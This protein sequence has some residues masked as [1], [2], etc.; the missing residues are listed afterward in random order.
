[1]D[2]NTENA[3]TSEGEQSKGREKRL[4]KAVERRTVDADA[5]DSAHEDAR[6]VL[7][8]TLRLFSDLSNE[9]FR[10][11]R[12]NALVITILVAVTSQVT[13]RL[14]SN[15][16][17]VAS[18]LL[19][20]ASTAFALAGYMT[21]TVNRGIDT[22]TFGKLTTYKLDQTEYLNWV[23]T[24]GYP[25]WIADGVRKTDRKEQWIRRSFVAFF[26][27]FATLLAGILLSLY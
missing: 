26:A 19:F 23:L 11:I 16:S 22:R 2:E 7:E 25:K 17:S 24:L 12:L 21:T 8:Q 20:V 9:A 15:V 27:G 4:Q 14:Y 5:L 10:L 3:E 1:M 18:L 13:V 6:L